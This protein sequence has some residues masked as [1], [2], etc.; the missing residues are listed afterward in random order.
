MVIATV[1]NNNNS[2]NNNNKKNFVLQ[3][4]GDLN[5]GPPVSDL[6]LSMPVGHL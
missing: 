2:N 5:L 3:W 6:V 1:N 4:F